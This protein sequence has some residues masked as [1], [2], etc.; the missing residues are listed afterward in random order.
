MDLTTL[1]ICF[2]YGLLKLLDPV[3]PCI[4]LAE[5]RF[6]IITDFS[7]TFT[8]SLVDFLKQ[9]PGFLGQKKASV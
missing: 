1:G 9:R 7:K 4:C 6:D 5:T 3:G 8:S 2:F